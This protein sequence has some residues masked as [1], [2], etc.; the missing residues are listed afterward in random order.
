VQEAPGREPS[1][2]TGDRPP[3]AE[4]TT[5]SGADNTTGNVA[6]GS[7]GKAR[8]SGPPPG[9]GD[10]EDDDDGDDDGDRGGASAPRHL[11]GL[12]CD[13]WV[14]WYTTSTWEHHS[15]EC[16]AQRQSRDDAE[17]SRQEEDAEVLANASP[18]H[19]DRSED[20]HSLGSQD[21]PDTAAPPEQ[22]SSSLSLSDGSPSSAEPS[23]QITGSHHQPDAGTLTQE[24]YAARQMT[25]S[26][27]NEEA[28]PRRRGSPDSRRRLTSSPTF[29]PGHGGEPTGNAP[30]FGQPPGADSSQRRRD[31][32]GYT[33]NTH[34]PHG[35]RHP[36]MPTRHHGNAQAIALARIS[37]AAVAG[38]TPV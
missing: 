28:G 26:V 10:D 9:D 35:A 36:S 19:H 30:T 24:A 11:K 12:Y 6:T 8:D 33:V 23:V 29:T 21:T 18:P 13:T 14:P 38:N 37:V 2:P 17:A 34:E 32:E 22:K 5:G 31:S 25:S 16:W 4:E 3:P 20:E 15:R 7:P 27:K 1:T